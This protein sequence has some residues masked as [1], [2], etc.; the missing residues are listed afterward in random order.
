ME[1]QL[2]IKMATRIL[3]FFFASSDFKYENRHVVYRYRTI[4][5]NAL[6]H[7]T[8][9]S[10]K[11][12]EEILQSMKKRILE[13]IMA[14]QMEERILAGQFLSDAPRTPKLDRDEK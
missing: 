11:K 14:L 5:E 9:R 4:M 6:L 10:L 3:I 2:P 1:I 8:M 12:E 7:Q 13:Q